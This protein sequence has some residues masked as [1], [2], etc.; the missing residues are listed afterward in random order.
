MPTITPCFF[1]SGDGLESLTGASGI[2]C[3]PSYRMLYLSVSHLRCCFVGV[4]ATSLLC[5]FVATEDCCRL[6]SDLLPSARRR[7]PL[8]SFPT[9]GIGER[10]TDVRHGARITTGE[11]SN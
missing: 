7:P 2:G 1:S 9:R 3:I 4:K 11:S 8:T 10:P 6:A 5:V